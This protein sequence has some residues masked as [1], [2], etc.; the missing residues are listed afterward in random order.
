MTK[1]GRGKVGYTLKRATCRHACSNQKV[2]SRDDILGKVGVTRRETQYVW[3]AGG[4]KRTG[5]TSTTRE[6]VYRQRMD[7]KNKSRNNI[8][9]LNLP[10]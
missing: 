6:E 5:G 3:E 4:I 7:R 9:K 8:G 2:T 10:A 1:M